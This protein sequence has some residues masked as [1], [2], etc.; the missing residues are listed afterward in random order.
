MEKLGREDGGAGL[1]PRQVLVS[2]AGDAFFTGDAFFN[3]E[4]K[5][6]VQMYQNPGLCYI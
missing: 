6:S 4:I 1:A 2:L 5:R 3:R